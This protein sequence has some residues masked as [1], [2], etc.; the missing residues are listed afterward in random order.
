MEDL[1]GEIWVDLKGYEGLYQVSNLGRIKSLIT[2][3]IL[4]Q[5]NNSKGYFSVYICNKTKPKKIYIHQLVAIC[6]LNFKPNKLKK[7]IDHI[8]GDP[9]NNKLNNLQILTHRENIVKGFKSKVSKSNKRH[10][11]SIQ[12]NGIIIYLGHFDNRI[13]AQKKRDE[14]LNEFN[15]TGILPKSCANF[16]SDFKGVSYNKLRCKW[17]AYSYVNKKRIH[18]GTYE[19]EFEAIKAKKSFLNNN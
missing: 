12:V 10:S 4:K 11:Y 18:I 17:I 13:D 1:Y 6:F 3:R 2:K 16:Y 8:D 5:I 14:V 9:S 15:K 19:T 7:V